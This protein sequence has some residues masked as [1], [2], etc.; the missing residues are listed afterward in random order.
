M[1]G[2]GRSGVSR[3][4][5]LGVG[6]PISLLSPLPAVVVMLATGLWSQVVVGVS[7]LVLGLLNPIWA[8]AAIRLLSKTGASEEA[9]AVNLRQAAWL[10]GIVGS[11]VVVAGLVP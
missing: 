9:A 4:L 5:L 2:P 1:T 7:W 6:L 11:V 10:V 3:D 8:P